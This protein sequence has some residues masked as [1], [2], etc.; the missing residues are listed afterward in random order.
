MLLFPFCLLACN[1]RE[2]IE[3]EMRMFA[4]QVITIEKD[5]LHNPYS[6]H[7][8]LYPSTPYTYVIYSDPDNCSECAINHISDWSDLDMER[9]VQKGILSYMFILA[10]ENSRLNRIKSLIG[11][12]NLNDYAIYVDTCGYFERNNELL[13]SNHLLHTFMIDK[14]N[15][16][17]L[18]GNPISNPQ[19]KK[20]CIRILS[21]NQ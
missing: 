8:N 2:N 1:S 6:L 17:V 3:E 19:I 16:V 10:P 21:D 14:T 5:S 18:I 4:G 20:M 7:T 12:K 11:K 15:K 13:P 9:Y